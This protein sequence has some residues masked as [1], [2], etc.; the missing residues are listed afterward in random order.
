MNRES[1]PLIGA[2]L[3]PCILVLII[4][5]FYYGYDITSFLRQFPLIYYIVIVPI[6]LGFVVGVIKFIRPD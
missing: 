1:L 2:L 4:I 6:A 3:V 5:M